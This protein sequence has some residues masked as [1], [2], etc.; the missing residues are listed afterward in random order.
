MQTLTEL[1]L[2][3]AR[4]GIFTHAEVSCW[5]GGTTDRRHALLKRALAAGEVLRIRRGLYIL[6]PR[7]VSRKPDPFVLAQ[8][9]YGPGYISLESALSR[10]GW[11]P[12]ATYGI[13]SASLARSCEFD[14]PLGHFS[15]ARVPQKTLYA[16]V[17]R[18]E[19][20]EDGGSFFVASPVKALADYVYVHQCDWASVQP[21]IESLRIEEELLAGLS[22]E[23]LRG[24]A[25]NYASKRVRRF[26]GGLRE[27]AT[28]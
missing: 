7:F 27:E 20:G 6:A 12:E 24:L 15:F 1:A 23:V 10:H 28:R 14:T 19:T 22:P 9:I 2:E 3:K 25:S 26:L 11:I 16:G 21:L 4:Q 5:V 8:R 13:T 17:E 18:V